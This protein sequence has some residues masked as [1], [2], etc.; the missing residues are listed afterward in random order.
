[1]TKIPENSCISLTDASGVISGPLFIENVVLSDEG[2]VPFEFTVVPKPESTE[3]VLN[4]V[5]NVG[6]CSKGSNKANDIA[7]GDYYASFT[8]DPFG[9]A[10][11]VGLKKREEAEEILEERN[12]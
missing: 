11:R 3:I 2:L 4:G 12:S 9:N 5:F 8:I 1:M 7:N 6:W 10:G